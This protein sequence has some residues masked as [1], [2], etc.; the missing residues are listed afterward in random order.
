MSSYDISK[1]FLSNADGANF[2]GLQPLKDPFGKAYPTDRGDA[3]VLCPDCN[4]HDTVQGNILEHAGG[5]FGCP[6]VHSGQKKAHHEFKKHAADYPKVHFLFQNPRDQ[7]R[8]HL[9]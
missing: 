6:K 1:G 8:D 9:L 3:H 7:V 5:S 2:R 4:N